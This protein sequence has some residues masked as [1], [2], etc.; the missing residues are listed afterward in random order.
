MASSWPWRPQSATLDGQEQIPIIRVYDQLLF[1]CKVVSNS[2]VTPRTVAL[3][4]PLSLRF[5]MQEYWS[6]FPFP[7]PGDLCNPGIE[8]MSLALAGG[9]F[10]T[11]LPGKSLWSEL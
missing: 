4:V 2:F 6:G 9:F 5:P 1:S 8:L 10:I 7:S 3:Q 11:E